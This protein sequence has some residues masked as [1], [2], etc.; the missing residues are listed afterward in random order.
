MAKSDAPCKK[1]KSYTESSRWHA[2]YNCHIMR[3]VF[4]DAAGHVV[5]VRYTLNDDEQTPVTEEAWRE[6]VAWRKECAG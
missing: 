3:T 2:S 5:E 4:R 1:W 6:C